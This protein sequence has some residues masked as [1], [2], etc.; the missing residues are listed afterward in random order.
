V[1]KY[2]WNRCTLMC[3]SSRALLKNEA[4]SVINGKQWAL[5]CFGP[6]KECAVVPNFILDKSFEEVRMEFI[7]HSKT[8]NIQN[9]VQ[10]LM[11]EYNGAIQKLNELKMPSSDAIQIIA[12]IYVS[13]SENTAV[14]STVSTP[15]PFQSSNMLISTNQQMSTTSIFGSSSSSQSSNPFQNQTSNIFTQQQQQQP[16]SLP[17]QQN[18]IFNSMTS[19]PLQP[20]PSAQTASIFSS[21]SQATNIFAQYNAP[22]Q[23]QQQQSSIFEAQPHSAVSL[24]T[25]QSLPSIFGT[26]Q[27]PFQQ[28]Q[29]AATA[30]QQH[31]SG[32]PFQ[33]PPP[34]LSVESIDEGIYSQPGDLSAEDNA[35]FQAENFVYGKIPC[36]PPSANF[37]M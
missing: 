37:C 28:V 14:K 32:N 8:G 24:Q 36:I 30:Q 35:A 1:R 2:S 19:S 26:N 23:Q 6:F 27:N 9:Y 3:F 16:P 34:P 4:E 15:N 5:S 12:S 13:P 29:M 10:S 7:E 17:Q 11:T 20:A 33:P 22:L 31:F 21:G 25:T 18:S